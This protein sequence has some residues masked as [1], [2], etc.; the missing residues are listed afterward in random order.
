MLSQF[1]DA[2]SERPKGID[3]YVPERKPPRPTTTMTLTRKSRNG[4]EVL[5]GLRADTMPAFPGF[6]AFPGGGLSRVDSQSVDELEQLQGEHAKAIAAMS[7]EMVE[8]LGYA[9]NGNKMVAVDD[10]SRNA[11]IKDK[12]NW[13]PLVR[14]GKIPC[15]MD[16]IK[17]ISR[18]ITPPFAPVSFDNVFLHL[19]AG[20]KE[21]L[22]EINLEEQT[23]FVD[24]MWDTPENIFNKWKN[25]EIKV[26]PPVV[27]LLHTFIKMISKYGNDI[28]SIS[29][30]LSFTKPGKRA[31]WFAYGVEVI[32][33]QTATL[34]PATHTNCYLVGEPNSDFIIVDPAIKLR[35]DM[36][37]LAN[38][39]DRHGGELQ[40]IL[41]THGHSD[42][43]ADWDLLREAF[44]VPIWSSSET[45]ESIES[46]KKVSVSM[47]VEDGDDIELGQVTWKALK[48]PGHDA[49]HICLLSDAGLI[50]G[51]MVA[52]IGTILIPSD[53]GN[54]EVYIEQL[55]RLKNMNPNLVFPSHGPIIPLPQKKFNFYIKH[56]KARNEKIINAI[57][58]G[59][60][61]I[62]VIS[63]IAYEDSPNAHPGLALDQTRSHLL[64]LER[65]GIVSQDSNSWALTG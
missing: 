47:V 15:S 27:S 13:L 8:E 24:A 43:L 57:R 54:M 46:S 26:A 7:R 39:V 3:F 44:D 20:D 33:V 35:E 14:E 30:E 22:V 40:A 64:S 34:P 17:V 4:I 16:G 50:A 56:R 10:D 23:E 51:D 32:P 18:R 6:W 37:K 41:F 42:H 11:V 48:T 2:M 53:T 65:Q 62:D 58:N 28:D 59:A 49:G 25:H 63:K 52:G 29:E 36:E 12:T 60:E 45:K 61:K 21:D 5:L 31:I 38:A 9:W 19:H 1:G 55:E